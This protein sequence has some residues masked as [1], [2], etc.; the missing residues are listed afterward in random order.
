MLELVQVSEVP[1][2]IEATA[3]ELARLVACSKRREA[4]AILSRLIPVAVFDGGD[5]VEAPSFDP[6]R[7]T[8]VLLLRTVALDK[9]DHKAALAIDALSE[10]AMN[11]QHGAAARLML[12]QLAQEPV[13]QHRPKRLRALAR[14]QAR[15]EI[16]TVGE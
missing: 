4:E 6:V 16:S 12:D 5:I 1:S 2:S 14:V 9:D 7:R 13:I 15:L 11:R 10:W 8:V 3:Q